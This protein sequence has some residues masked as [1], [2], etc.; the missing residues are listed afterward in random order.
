MIKKHDSGSW[1]I[2]PT[3]RFKPGDLISRVFHHEVYAI[4]SISGKHP[5]WTGSNKV[6]YA[7]VI[8]C[9]YIENDDTPTL[10]KLCVLD[11]TGRI[12]YVDNQWYD[13]VQTAQ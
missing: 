7:L 13:L 12:Q 6:E 3:I 9:D 4:N 2:T 10:L 11:H 5:V 8:Y 1:W